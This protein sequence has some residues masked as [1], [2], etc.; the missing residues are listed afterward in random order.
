MYSLAEK[1]TGMPSL[2]P[3]VIAYLEKLE[4]ERRMLDICNEKAEEAKFIK[5]RQEGLQ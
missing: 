3:K 2:S 5:A 1:K 4:T